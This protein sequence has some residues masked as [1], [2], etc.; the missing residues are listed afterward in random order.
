M[1]KMLRGLKLSIYEVLTPSEEEEE[2][3][4]AVTSFPIRHLLTLP[5]LTIDLWVI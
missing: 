3:A 5:V 1:D 2:E 4:L